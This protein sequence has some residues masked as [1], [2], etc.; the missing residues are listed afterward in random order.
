MY[1]VKWC[2][3]TVAGPLTREAAD[4]YAAK[5]REVMI[6]VTVEPV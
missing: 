5:V 6:G 3:V 1:A 2:G 4:A